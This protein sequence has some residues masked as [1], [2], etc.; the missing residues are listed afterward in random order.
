MR[1]LLVNRQRKK[2]RGRQALDPSEACPPLFRKCGSA[3]SGRRNISSRPLIFAHQR[4]SLKEFHQSQRGRCL[5]LTTRDASASLDACRSGRK[6]FRPGPGEAAR[7]T[8]DKD[9]RG[10]GR[11]DA[12]LTFLLMAGGK[13]ARRWLSLGGRCE[14]DRLSPA[15]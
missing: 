12:R 4:C 8:A 9:P 3:F 10:P 1:I 15:E 2:K 6:L 13:T 11:R 7:G 14:F 5:V